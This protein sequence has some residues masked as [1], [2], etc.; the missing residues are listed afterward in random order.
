[1]RSAT[2]KIVFASMLVLCA[3]FLIIFAFL[4]GRAEPDVS[5]TILTE[6]DVASPV[7]EQPL[8]DKVNINAADVEALAQIPGV[9]SSLAEKIVSYRQEWGRFYSVYD[10]LEVEGFTDELLEACADYLVV[11]GYK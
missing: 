2:G 4:G 8:Q 10:L 11:G 9:T 3:V 1:M 5:V 7:L 6:D